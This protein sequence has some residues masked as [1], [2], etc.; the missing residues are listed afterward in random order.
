V[1][2]DGWGGERVPV[3]IEVMV[4]AVVFVLGSVF[5]FGWFLFVYS[6]LS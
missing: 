5:G 4:F 1:C 3:R 6:A 2:A